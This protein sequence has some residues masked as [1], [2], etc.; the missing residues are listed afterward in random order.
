MPVGSLRPVRDESLH[1]AARSILRMLEQEE[2]AK[3]RRGTTRLPR[4]LVVYEDTPQDEADIQR[5][6]SRSLGFLPTTDQP[7]LTHSASRTDASEAIQ[8]FPASADSL[9]RLQ[10]AQTAPVSSPSPFPIILPPI[11]IPG[12]KENEQWVR[13]ASKLLRDL[14]RALSGGGPDCGREWED[15]RRMCEEELAKPN[16]SR[17]IT[18]GYTNRDDCARGLVSEQCGGNKLAPRPRNSGGFPRFK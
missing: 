4:S 5:G 7:S 17:G 15:A 11:A 9:R 3:R 10:L 6:F 18:G 2:I 16:P 13:W 1:R 12:S 8:D 14:G